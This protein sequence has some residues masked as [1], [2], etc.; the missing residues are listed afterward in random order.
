MRV[1][2]L[3]RVLAGPTAARTL[4]EHGAHVLRIASAVH[5]DVGP[6]P[7]DTGHGKRSTM[8]DLRVASDIAALRRLVEGA[9]VF[10]QGY[11]P[12]AIARLGFSPEEL[13]TIRPGIISLSISAYGE[14]GPWRGMRGFDSVVEAGDGTA[15]EEGG[16]DGGE[17]RLI[18]ASPLDYTTGY[19]AAFLVQVALERRA[20]EGGSYHIELSLAQTGRYLNDLPRVDAAAAAGRAPELP[21]ARLVTLRTAGCAI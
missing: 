8:L 3:T 7:R 11:R 14:T 15:D 18:P 10:S 19:L 16:A 1:L 17:P 13:A 21:K 4:A 20:R 6:M 12:G 9:D 2:D 5:R